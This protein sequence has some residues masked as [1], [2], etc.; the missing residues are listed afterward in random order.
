VRREEGGALEFLVK[1]T[2][3]RRDG[4]LIAEARSVVVVRNPAVP[5]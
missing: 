2:N 5:Q 4:E 1:Q 3:T